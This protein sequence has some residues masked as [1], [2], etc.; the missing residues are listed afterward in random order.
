MCKIA[1]LNHNASLFRD[2]EKHERLSSALFQMNDNE[3]SHCVYCG[4]LDC[5][6][7]Q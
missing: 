5:R 4:L 6:R 2:I 1:K 7:N 3:I